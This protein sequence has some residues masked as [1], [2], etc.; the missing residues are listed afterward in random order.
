MVYGVRGRPEDHS[1]LID[2]MDRGVYIVSFLSG[3]RL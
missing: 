3:N 1:H 2:G